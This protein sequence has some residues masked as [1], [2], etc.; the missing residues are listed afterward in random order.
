MAPRAQRNTPIHTAFTEIIEKYGS[1]V[2]HEYLGAVTQ[3]L[4]AIST[5]NKALAAIDASRDEAAYAQTVDRLTEATR[6]Y[7]VYFGKM[8]EDF[9]R[10][11]QM[12]SE[13]E[14]KNP[15]AL[16]EISKI[17]DISLPRNASLLP[18]LQT[19]RPQTYIMQVDAITNQLTGLRGSDK[20]KVGAR[21]STPVRTTVTL[22]IP[23]H[24][25]IDGGGVLTTY[26]KSILNGVTSLLES[27]NPVFSIPMLYHAMTGK[28]NPTVDEQL[29]EELS[30]KLAKMR[31][32]TISIDMSEENNAHFFTD[33]N[34]EPRAIENVVIEGYLLP[35]NKMSG[36]INGKKAELF[37]VLQH[38]PLYTYSKMRR[39]LASVPI[40]LLNAPINNNS[41]TIPL[42][43]YL[44]QRIEMMKN[45][46]NSIRSNTILYET[47]YAE[48]GDQ[49]AT[50]TRKMRIRTYATTILQYFVEQG[51]IKGYQEFKRERS[52]A[53][54]QIEL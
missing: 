22:D 34:G 51:Y 45:P 25:R 21:G 11:Y 54:I 3:R 38:P 13:E 46:K 52:I 50:K 14:P 20:L 28:Q 31:Q 5:L 27:G 44:L 23:Q 7:Y 30:G 48:L 6:E 9:R 49:D 37:Q 36:I 43:T 1:D 4:E 29:Y 53:G 12:L 35:L 8:P 42:K 26:D 19:I 40:T 41:T 39:Q 47:V 33:E 15:D 32:L 16:D 18:S 2:F 24:M 10:F 17:L